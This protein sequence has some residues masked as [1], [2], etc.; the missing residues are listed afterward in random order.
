MSKTLSVIGRDVHKQFVATAA[1]VTNNS[2][3]LPVRQL[4][5]VQKT[6]GCQ[7]TSLGSFSEAGRVFDAE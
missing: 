5:K 2:P 6:L 7:K 3:I 1:T 4:E